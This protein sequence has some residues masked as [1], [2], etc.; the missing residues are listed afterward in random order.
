M[1]RQRGELI[2]ISDVLAGR[3]GPMKALRDASP[4]AVH[5]FTQADQVNQLVG[6][7]EA[8][9]DLGFMARTMALCSLPRS[10]PRDRL[11]YIRQNVPSPPPTPQ[12][13]YG[14][15]TV[16]EQKRTLSVVSRTP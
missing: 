8:D 9:P 6:A 7:S 12:V 15:P 4:Q 2:P 3:G 1:Q 11:R 10:N 5:H 16:T 14:V 13:V